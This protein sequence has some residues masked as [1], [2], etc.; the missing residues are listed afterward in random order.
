MIATVCLFILREKEKNRVQL[1]SRYWVGSY[2]INYD[3][4]VHNQKLRTEKDYLNHSKKTVRKRP[5]KPLTIDEILALE[6][7]R[8][9]DWTWGL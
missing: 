9:L 1:I 5:G 4:C 2:Y 6:F 8:G 7:D 3:V